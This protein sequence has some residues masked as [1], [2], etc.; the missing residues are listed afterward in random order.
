[1]SLHKRLIDLTTPRSLKA[2]SKR[3]SK[4]FTFLISQTQREEE[5]NERCK[6]Q[7]LNI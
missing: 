7:N 4:H 2:D 1:M 5:C 3:P 6:R